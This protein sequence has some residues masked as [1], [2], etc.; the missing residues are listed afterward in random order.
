MNEPLIEKNVECQ[1]TDGTVLRADV[2]RPKKDG[3]YPVLLIRL[4]YDKETPRYYDEYLHVPRMVE[5]GYVVILQDVRGRFASDGEFYP[6]IHEADDGYESVEWAASLPY[7]NGKVGLFG[8]SYHGF[9]QLAAAAAFPPSLK[10]VA[11][12]MT[13]ADPWADMLSGGSGP[14]SVGNIKTWTLASMVQDELQRNNDPKAEQ[15]NQYIEQLPEWLHETPSNEWTP[16]KDLRPNSYFFDVINERVPASFREKMN[17]I[18]KLKDVSIPALFIGGWFDSLLKPTL[19]AYQAY[20]GEKMLWIGPWTHE[21]MT[22][23]AGGKYFDNAQVEI[24][25]DNIKDPTEL[26]ILWF[27]HWLKG[28]PHTIEK[29][30]HLYLM[31]QKRWEN[32]DRWPP[33]PV[34]EKT[35]YLHSKGAANSRSGDGA[36]TTSLS[37]NQATDS[38]RLDPANPVPTHGGGV[39]IAGHESGMFDQGDIQDRDDILVYTSETLTHDIDI[40]GTIHAEIW[41]ASPSPLLDLFVRISDVEPNGKAY[42]IVDSFHRE[43]VKENEKVRVKMDVNHTAYRFQTGH[44]IRVEIAASN[45]PMFDVNLNNGKTTKT[46]SHGKAAYETIYHGGSCPSHIVL[47]ISPYA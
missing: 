43:S 40:L 13:M 9:T 36:L 46:A 21:E 45:A 8:M 47:P 5:A 26:H 1:L 32:Y 37:G 23:R 7:S 27:N 30:V 33:S 11:P 35:Y 19:K 18:D 42:N 3:V 4:P 24:G 41:A 15:V 10:A 14:S 20:G 25:K 31:G 12:V 38:L 2:Y 6:F 17:V 34:E 39:L 28:K 44:K 29:P 22:G 16:M